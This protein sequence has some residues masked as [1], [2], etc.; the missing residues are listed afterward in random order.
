MSP[1]DALRRYPLLGALDPG[2]ISPWL[3]SAQAVAI[4]V[5][6]LVF[7]AGTPGESVYVVEEGYVRVLRQGKGGR[8]VSLGSYGPGDLFGEYALIRPGQ[9]TAT[10]RARSAAR[11]YRL[12]LAPLRDAIHARPEVRR[13]L[14]TWLRLHAALGYL[15]GGPFLGFQSAPAVLQLLDC[16]DPIPFQAGHAIQADGLSARRLFVIRRG[17]VV[18]NPAPGDAAGPPFTLGAGDCFGARG[19]LGQT[20][21]PFA[22]ARTDVECLV[23]ARWVFESSD[24]TGESTMQT[25]RAES[26][27][28]RPSFWVAQKEASD[29]GVACLAMIARFH[30][31]PVTLEE[32]HQRL[33]PGP[34]GCSL[35]ELQRAAESLGLG[36]R[37]V[38][39]IPEHLAHV[40]LPAVAH[41]DERHYVVVYVAEEG[42]VVMG[43]PAT[44][45]VT[46][47]ADVFAQ[48]WSKQLL[49]VTPPAETPAPPSPSPPSQ[50]VMTSEPSFDTAQL[51]HYLDRIRAGDQEAADALMLKVCARLERLARHMLRG[52]PGVKRWADTDDVLQSALVRLLR[53]LQ[54]VR[55]E[56][57]RDFVNLAA[58]H[59]RRELIDLARHFRSRINTA[60]VALDEI[61]ADNLGDE[62][63][64]WSAFHEQVEQ[65]PTEEREVIMLTFY[66]GWAQAQIAELF[67]VD[68]RTVRRRWRSGCLKLSEALG[69]R[70][71]EA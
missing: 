6:E 66:H 65:L 49:L 23:L 68:E 30:G 41:L 15:R 22:E 46:I 45:I 26:P 52:F 2:R 13:L 28:R 43:D 14:K 50:P 37:P 1:H 24:E 11:L 27:R 33:Q 5:G 20:G 18:V 17:E 67:Q 25:F 53:A 10:C 59:I 12:P 4:D 16:F 9:N 57:T 8:E 56:T 47:G 36:A 58:V 29:C 42:S 60:D 54:A 70:M 44:G 7:Q 40:A 38:P 35:L 63:D 31:R 62:L 39:I 64:L 19:V 61:D 3:D 32:V 48:A 71:P 21:L 51:H 69:G 55:P 34:H